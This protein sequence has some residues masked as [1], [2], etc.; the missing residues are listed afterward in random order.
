MSTGN[1]GMQPP[2][3]VAPGSVVPLKLK[4]PRPPQYRQI[5]LLIFVLLLSVFSYF[6]FS[7]YVLMSVEITGT[8]M[9]P[10]LFNGERY[11]LFRCPYLWRAPRQGEIVVIKDPEDHGLSI[12]RIVA[13]PN[14][15]IEIR[16]D[17]VFVNHAKLPEPYL[18]SFASF[19]TCAA[20]VK[21]VRLGSDDY[22]VLGD[23]RGR[24]ADSR[25]YGP[26]SRKDILGLISKSE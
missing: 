21:P 7:R 15:V 25:S 18:A 23:N 16:R 24:S 20:P 3:S 1:E 14:D 10:T 4:Q 2:V 19:E 11:I 13:L 9:S 5:P 22:Y 12:K 26:V 6:L 8:S 17:G